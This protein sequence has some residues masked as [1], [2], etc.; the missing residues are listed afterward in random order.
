MKLKFVLPVAALLL[1]AALPAQASQLSE[2]KEKMVTARKELVTMVMRPD[3][4]GADQQKLVKD[5]AD[6]VSAHFATLK[7]PPAQ[8][9]KYKELRD[10]W[11]A[12]KHTRETELVPA[13]LAGDKQKAEKIASGIQKERL[14]KCYA[15]ITELDK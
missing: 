11:E 7:I 4:R 12:F 3:K 6:A 8:A 10:S 9:G 13:I 15:L 14:D 1:G 5:S 2:L